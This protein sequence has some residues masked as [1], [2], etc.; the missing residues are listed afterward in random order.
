MSL[1]CSG[2]DLSAL[3]FDAGSG[4]FK[5][6]RAGDDSPAALF[7]SVVGTLEQAEAERHASSTVGGGS[8]GSLSGGERERQRRRRRQR[9]GERHIGFEAL[10]QPRKSCEVQSP[11]K[12]GLVE[13]WDLLEDLW[14][15]GIG[16]LGVDESSPGP[17]VVVSLSCQYGG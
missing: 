13:D 2:D 3:V 12:R 5:A 8:G 17:F 15:H 16:R 6:G 14:A 9:P 11:F 1:F 4:V 10:N 7:P